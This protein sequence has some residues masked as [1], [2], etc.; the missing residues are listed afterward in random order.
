[1]RRLLTVLVLLI[2]IISSISTASAVSPR[3]KADHLQRCDA[4]G[5]LVSGDV[6][7]LCSATWQFTATCSG[8][9]L[10][11]KWHVSGQTQPKDSFVHPWADAPVTVIGYELVKTE[12]P[13]S[14]PNPHTSWFMI[15]S[16]IY[17]QPDT[18][19]WL[20]P[21]ETHAKQMW[22]A[23]IG[24]V[25]PSKDNATENGNPDFIDLHGVCYG[26]GPIS[27]FM[28]IYYTPNGNYMLPKG[29]HP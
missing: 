5:V 26:G 9:D 13:E 16:A 24:Q 23:G 17:P 2:P 12:A 25:W 6:N 19:L 8:E 1:M 10:W 22:P 15:G 20:A 3:A 28:T 7:I 21:G 18:M 4:Q 27:I 11:N 14:E 29:V